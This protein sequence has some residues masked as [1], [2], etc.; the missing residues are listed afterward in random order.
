M[1]TEKRTYRKRQRRKPGT[2]PPRVKSTDSDIVE[3]WGLKGGQKAMY[4]REHREEILDYLQAHGEVETRRRYGVSR[5]DVISEV[6]KNWDF[7][8]RHKGI[9]PTEKLKLEM[10]IQAEDIIDLKKEIKELKQL[11]LTFRESVGDQLTAK[12]FVPLMKAAIKL[13]PKLEQ[14][15]DP[16]NP[17]NI[18]YILEQTNKK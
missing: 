7:A 14:P 10:A 11:F 8:A 4:L 5:L 13:D 17:L 9:T 18:E 3:L 1:I 15:K 2:L 12:F 16:I 6:E